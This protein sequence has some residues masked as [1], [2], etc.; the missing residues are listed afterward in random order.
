MPM[1][2]PVTPAAGVAALAIHTTSLFLV[3]GVLALVV[4]R[5]VG[6]DVLRRVWVNL[7]LVWAGALIVAALATVLLP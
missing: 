2:S 5:T 4:Y 1:H 3:M 7:D 6:V